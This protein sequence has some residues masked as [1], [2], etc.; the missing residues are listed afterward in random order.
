MI[1]DRRGVFFL[2]LLK[3]YVVKIEFLDVIVVRD[4]ML[5]NRK[6][7]VIFDLIL[8]DV[9]VFQMFEAVDLVCKLLNI[10]RRLKSDIILREVKN[11]D[12]AFV[13]S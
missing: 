1:V 9:K 4:D 13:V 11:L 7:V 8:F 12:L 6:Q 3:F 5:L 2:I 10:N